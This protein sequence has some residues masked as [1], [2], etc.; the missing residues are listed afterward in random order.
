MSHINSQL[1]KALKVRTPEDDTTVNM[2][3][4]ILP[5]RKEAAYRRLRGEIEFTLEEVE[6][7]CKTFNL[8]LDFLQGNHKDGLLAFHLR[9]VF[10]KNPLK[11]YFRMMKDI[12]VN[13]NNMLDLDPDTFAYRA[14]RAMPSDFFLKYDS[15]SKVYI[16][17]LFYQLYPDEMPKVLLH[18]MYIPNNVFE[19]NRKVS[20]VLQR[21]N[22]TIIL[23][24]HIFEDFTSIVKYLQ[25]MGMISETD[26]LEIKNDLYLMINEMEQ[27]ASTGY[28]IQGKSVDLYISNVSFDCSYAYMEGAGK[29]SCAISLYCI[30]YLSCLNPEIAENQKTWIKS[31]I[32]FATQISV[33]G[34]LQ[35]NQYFAEQRRYVDAM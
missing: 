28:T 23:D 3:M 17:I 7:I 35:R 34:E 18:D 33:S 21:V 10:D 22:A 11:E 15:I 14:Y 13:I 30:D 24:K 12:V 32:R 19:I 27:C 25:Y 8:S 9:S 20:D 6:I 4:D 31:L 2:L 26:I 1:I 5:I 16:Y 29:K